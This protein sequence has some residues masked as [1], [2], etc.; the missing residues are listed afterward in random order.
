[1][2]D[3]SAL[4]AAQRCACRLNTAREAVRLHGAD[5]ERIP[6]LLR[7]RWEGRRSALRGSGEGQLSLRVLRS[8]FK[9]LYNGLNLR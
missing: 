2:E 7:N 5:H 4:H 1:M 8:H 6:A 3:A 9:T